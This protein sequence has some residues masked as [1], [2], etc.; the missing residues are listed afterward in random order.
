[1]LGSRGL[2]LPFAGVNLNML[3]LKTIQT[4]QARIVRL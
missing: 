2:F 4:Y 3:N 1:M